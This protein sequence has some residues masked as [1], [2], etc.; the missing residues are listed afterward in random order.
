[1]QLPSLF[2]ILLENDLCQEIDLRAQVTLLDR[3]QVPTP[4][5]E[6]QQF[7]RQA[8]AAYGI[9]SCIRNPGDVATVYRGV[10][11]RHFLEIQAL[12][13]DRLGRSA[14]VVMEI[15]KAKALNAG[16][17][18]IED[19]AVW[20]I[21]MYLNDRRQQ[22]TTATIEQTDA[23]W[24]IIVVSLPTGITAVNDSASLSFA[25][26]IVDVS[27]DLVI[28][29]RTAASEAST[30]STNMALYDALAAT[31]RPSVSGQGGL[32]WHPP[33]TVL[34]D[35]SNTNPW[36]KK[37]CAELGITAT[38][39]STREVVDQSKTVQLVRSVLSTPRLLAPHGMS[40]SKFE[41]VFDRLLLIVQKIE[42]RR[43]ATLNSESYSH[44]RGFS[45]DPAAMLPALRWLLP[46]VESRIADGAVLHRGLHYTHELLELWPDRLAQLRVSAE[47]EARAWVYFEHEV[48]CA[49]SAAELRRTDGSLRPNR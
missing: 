16:A 38:E 13:C 6:R 14:E 26:L 37:A 18:M 45:Q 33:R 2:D 43:A 46:V 20:S 3:P 23:S 17:K 12:Y 36:L 47:A 44:L 31:R 42:P 9:D 11:T 15:Q 30:E 21:C 49:A 27:H 40:V 28:A 48:V 41:L 34:V 1:M 7:L 5:A 22:S 19:E 24:A 39:A 8:V 4:M 32:V 25:V 29:F 35:P 10:T